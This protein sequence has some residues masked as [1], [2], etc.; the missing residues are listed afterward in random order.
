MLDNVFFVLYYYIRS[1]KRLNIGYRPGVIM[2][3]FRQFFQIITLAFFLTMGEEATNLNTPFWNTP[4]ASQP[5]LLI[6]YP[7]DA[8]NKRECK[9]NLWMYALLDAAAHFKLD[10]CTSFKTITSPTLARSISPAINCK[11]TSI[12][13]YRPLISK[14]HATHQLIQKFE[15]NKKEQQVSL[16]IEIIEIASKRPI[17]SFDTRFHF[18]FLGNALDSCY[19]VCIKGLAGNRL[20]PEEVRFG[21]KPALCAG[22]P[23]NKR[24]GELLYSE[25][26]SGNTAPRGLAEQYL[27]ILSEEPSP[28][29][30]LWRKGKAGYR[31]GDLN[32]AQS[33]F[34]ALYPLFPDNEACGLALAKIFLRKKDIQTAKFKLASIVTTR[35]KPLPE[36][37]SVLGDAFLQSGDTVAALDYYRK[38]RTVHGINP[39]LQEKIAS[40]S[41]ILRQ[42]GEAEKEYNLLIGQKPN[43]P[44]ARYYLAY[45]QLKR[46]QIQL[47]ETTLQAAT[48]TSKGTAYL[49]EPI[50][51]CYA[52]LKNWKSAVR[53]WEKALGFDEKSP[54]IITKIASGLLT[55]GNDSLAAEYFVSLFGIDPKVHAASLARAG[56]LFVKCKAWDRASKSFD[57]YLR[58]GNSDNEVILSYARILFIEKNWKKVI[59]LLEPFGE[60]PSA[61]EEVLLMLA[62]ARCE[63]GEF[64]AAK[65]VLVSLQSM[66]QSSLEIIQL[67]ALAAEK[68]HDFSSAAAMYEKALSFPK[69][70]NA[71]DIAFRIG[72]IYEMENK[73]ERAIERY[74]TNITRFPTDIRNYER[75][76]DLYKTDKQ[77]QLLKLVLEKAITN[78]AVPSSMNLLLAQTYR[79]LGEHSLATV[80]FQT[81]LA[82]EP[83]DAEAWLDLGKLYYSRQQYGR[84][85]N[86]LKQAAAKL[87]KDFNCHTM[88]GICYAQKGDYRLAAASLE[89]A[90]KIDREN[91]SAIERLATCYQQ[92]NYDEKRLALLKRWVVL[93]KKRM[94]IRIE[95]S[96]SLISKG[97]NKEAI[98]I[99]KEALSIDQ[100][101]QKVQQLLAKAQKKGKKKGSSRAISLKKKGRDEG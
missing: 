71:Q 68:T 8:G 42:F 55:T 83:K 32:E 67:S 44:S 50:G 64:D 5:L 1:F 46:G 53:A 21:I 9:K 82:R 48:I 49:W 58:A 84:A 6:S 43:H 22:F 30:V 73:R 13:D 14:F 88:L 89:R 95:L 69:V 59:D 87:S 57:T 25:S 100:S 40:T 81:Y 27:K 12:P 3:R 76:V 65:P 18:D 52:A 94:D 37:F 24:T 97:K 26:Y 74:E 10:Y 61:T 98:K 35:A 19:F 11:E 23:N 70:E 17:V 39:L 99:L 77:L 51:D 28:L 80:M 31:D 75:L 93:D 60:S 86:P 62:R 63:T 4:S 29:L 33:S 54:R 16:F 96:T 34:H 47:A 36:V 101:N 85:I 20:S 15:I 45:L 78:I 38:E 2:I 66:N 92:C 41:F 91:I 56:L 79:T 7:V 72:N 90:H